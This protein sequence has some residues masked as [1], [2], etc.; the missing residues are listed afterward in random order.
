MRCDNDVLL[1]RSTTVD[2]LAVAAVTLR[3]KRECEGDNWHFSEW[4]TSVTGPKSCS[5]PQEKLIRTAT[6]VSLPEGTCCLSTVA[7]GRLLDSSSLALL[8]S[9]LACY[10][11][12]RDIQV[13]PLPACTAHH[14][15]LSKVSFPGNR[16]HALDGYQILTSCA[17]PQR[18]CQS[19]RPETPKKETK[20]YSL[21]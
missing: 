1:C 8:P 16:M 17:A 19:H 7:E 11:G 14:H 10:K 21:D 15:Q 13:W 12:H 18:S 6:L 2:G 4:F 20:R 9:S 3:W 5:V